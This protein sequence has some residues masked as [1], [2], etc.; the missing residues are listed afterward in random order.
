MVSNFDLFTAFFVD[1]LPSSFLSNGGADVIEACTPKILD[2][3]VSEFPYHFAV[4]I[5]WWVY[6]QQIP[7]MWIMCG[8]WTYGHAPRGYTLV[9]L[10]NGIAACYTPARESICITNYMCFVLQYLLSHTIAFTTILGR[11]DKGKTSKCICW[12]CL[13][14]TDLRPYRVGLYVWLFSNS[15]VQQWIIRLIEQKGNIGL[16]LAQ[17]TNAVVRY[18]YFI[19]WLPRAKQLL[20]WLWR[21]RNVDFTNA[22]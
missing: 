4:V 2:A 5:T 17:L 16:L 11:V 19:V 21:N 7:C 6:G 20:T 3:Q 9:F 22:P 1:A 18:N 10:H 13:G 14:I 12:Y 8:V 15:D